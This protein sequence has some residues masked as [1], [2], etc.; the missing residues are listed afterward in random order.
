MACPY[1]LT[2][3]GIESQLA[4]NYLGHFL[5]TNLLMPKILTAAA[6]PSSSIQ[7]QGEAT[8]TQTR[9]VNVSSVANRAAPPPHGI[10]F[11]D[12]N[13]TQNPQEYTPVSA[14]GQSKTAA[15]LFTIALN[16]RFANLGVNIRSWSLNPGS[17][18]TSL[19][20]YMTPQIRQNA[21]KDVFGED[22]VEFPERKTLQQGCATTLRAAL[23]PSLGL[24]EEDDGVYLNDCQIT[25]D[26]YWVAGWSLDKD[27]AEKLWAVSEE[28]VGEK[29]SF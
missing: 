8:K 16:K 24:E 11:F 15:I 5:L 9:I 25:K 3:D 20:Q 12:P 6:N 26:P 29:F 14:Y 19:G 23:D 1:R 22:T 4:A 28:L 21:L 27:S 13:Y 10:R 17:I 7:G 2:P 18:V